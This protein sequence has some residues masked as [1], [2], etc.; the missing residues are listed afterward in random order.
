[1]F[2]SVSKHLV[3]KRVGC[4]NFIKLSWLSYSMWN[5][6]YT[7]TWRCIASASQKSHRNMRR[8]SIV[9]CLFAPV[10]SFLVVPRHVRAH[11]LS[12]DT[13]TATATKPSRHRTWWRES[14]VALESDAKATPETTFVCQI[15]LEFPQASVST[16]RHRCQV[17]LTPMPMSAL[18]VVLTLLHPHQFPLL[19][20]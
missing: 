10:L 3:Q 20:T 7:I 4:R 15:A 13:P 14:A 5:R 9:F 18:K 11:R 12:Q 16:H 17:P 19:Q 2:S 6:E 8:F 1:M